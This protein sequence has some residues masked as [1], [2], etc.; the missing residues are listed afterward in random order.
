MIQA[1]KQQFEK[2]ATIQK[3]EL[4]T[5]PEFPERS[6]VYTEI[7]ID[8]DEV[9]RTYMSG[10]LISYTGFGLF[11]SQSMKLKELG[12]LEYCPWWNNRDESL[13]S[14]R[15]PVNN[16][17][18]IP[19]IY[20]FHPK[21]KSGSELNCESCYFSG[22]EII[23]YYDDT[24]H[25]TRSNF[26]DYFSDKYI[27]FEESEE[28]CQ[29]SEWRNRGK[30]V[31]VK[32]YIPIYELYTIEKDG[33]SYIEEFI[34]K[35]P[36]G[37]IDCCLL[38]PNENFENS[39]QYK[40]SFDSFVN[41][42]SSSRKEWYVNYRLMYSRY[43]EEKIKDDHIISIMDIGRNH[44]EI[45]IMRNLIKA[46]LSEGE[47][48]SL[49]FN[50]PAIFY[51]WHSTPLSIPSQGPFSGYMGILPDG[52][53]MKVDDTFFYSSN[54]L[55]GTPFI[56]PRKDSSYYFQGFDFSFKDMETYN[57]IF[58]SDFSDDW[59]K[60]SSDKERCLS[61]FSSDLKNIKLNF[62]WTNK[63]YYTEN[64]FIKFGSG[65]KNVP[66]KTLQKYINNMNLGML[67]GFGSTFTKN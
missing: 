24:N 32:A 53:T 17:I 4:T 3:K 19:S 8:M 52:V 31:T 18:N 34:D 51:E 7:K 65:A 64:D 39:F 23:P 42:T 45:Q 50:L 14:F 49:F 1:T 15:V 38:L 21:S 25:W 57:T 46:D 40:M 6:F 2:I 27:T 33:D 63:L 35:I 55:M 62:A 66:F 11:F 26:G 22:I 12:G 5:I 59:C 36:Q 54:K 29:Q 37:S 48:P 67:T 20:S 60:V 41:F 56:L 13:T 43:D 47:K 10:K 9:W 28:K 58:N 30:Y 61:K 44:D 16:W